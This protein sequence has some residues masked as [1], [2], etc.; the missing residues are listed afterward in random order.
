MMAGQMIIE[1]SH[2]TSV[3]VLFPLPL[4]YRIIYPELPN[5]K[6]KMNYITSQSLKVAKESFE[7]TFNQCSFYLMFLPYN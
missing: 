4:Y 1:L 2:W 5:R 7:I 6:C 3:L